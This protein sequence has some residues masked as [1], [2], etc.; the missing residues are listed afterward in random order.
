MWDDVQRYCAMRCYGYQLLRGEWRHSLMVLRLVLLAFVLDILSTNGR[1]RCHVETQTCSNRR[2]V[3]VPAGRRAICND[4]NIC[5]G[6]EVTNSYMTVYSFLYSLTYLHVRTITYM[7]FALQNL[8]I[9]KSAVAT[10]PVNWPTKWR[11][12]QFLQLCTRVSCSAICYL[13]IAILTA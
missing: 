13:K 5:T 6:H 12:S 7:S 3:L 1:L 8:F 10:I 9:D 2:V 11:H 4:L